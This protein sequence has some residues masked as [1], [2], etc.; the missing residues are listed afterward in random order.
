MHHS[1]T[2]ENLT[3]TLFGIL[4]VDITTQDSHTDPIRSL[5]SGSCSGM[6]PEIDAALG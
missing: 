1:D 6:R 3:L 5:R 4:G 2:P